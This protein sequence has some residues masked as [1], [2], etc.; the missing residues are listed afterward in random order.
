MP[1]TRK[2]HSAVGPAST[3]RVLRYN[4]LLWLNPWMAT[5][6]EKQ[7]HTPPILAEV[8][9]R[10]QPKPEEGS[11]I[12]MAW[13]RKDYPLQRPASVTYTQNRTAM[14]VPRKKISE[15]WNWT[16]K[17]A[18]C[19]QTAQLCPARV[20]SLAGCF[21]LL[22]LPPPAPLH[23][24][25]THTFSSFFSFHSPFPFEELWPAVLAFVWVSQPE[26]RLILPYQII[27]PE[28]HNLAVPVLPPHFLFACLPSASP[29]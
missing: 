10:L 12:S 8:R 24:H 7:H 25:S 23:S 20:F 11:P 16:G 4:P 1:N 19:A 3:V 21:I 27:L 28:L 6:G 18:D 22:C 2:D 26:A 15:S 17:P 5:H 13:P 29:L 14:W 9:M